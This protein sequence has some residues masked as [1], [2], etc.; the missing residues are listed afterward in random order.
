MDLN[1]SMGC[2]TT[3]TM[4]NWTLVAPCPI[5]SYF[6]GS[7]WLTELL[8]ANK[9]PEYKEYQQRVAKFIPRLSTNLPGN[10]SDQR[11][12]VEAGKMGKAET[13][14]SKDMKGNVAGNKGICTDVTGS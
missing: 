8:S 12:P 9:Y 5:Y 6:Q 7:T 1:I 2:W 14:P 10:F 13:K 3:E 4:Y 11:A